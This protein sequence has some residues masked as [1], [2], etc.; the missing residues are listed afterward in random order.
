[1]FYY[2]LRARSGLRNR[3]KREKQAFLNIKD[4]EIAASKIIFFLEI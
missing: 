2:F 4:N 3:E 1:M